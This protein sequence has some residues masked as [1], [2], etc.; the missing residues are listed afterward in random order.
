VNSATL[1]RVLVVASVTLT[2][3]LAVAV[4]FLAVD[5]SSLSHGIQAN[6]HTMC[7][8]GNRT[9]LATGHIV[10]QIVNQLPHSSK[11]AKLRHDIAVNYDH[12]NKCGKP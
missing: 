7:V 9:R 1:T 2:I 6:L 8:S 5:Y 4:I 10:G 12:Q 11:L 3:A